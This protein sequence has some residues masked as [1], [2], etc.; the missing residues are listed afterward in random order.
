MKYSDQ[1]LQVLRE[2]QS[3]ATL[4]LAQLSERTGIAQSTLWRKLQEFEKRGLIARRVSILNPKL[5]DCGLCVLAHISLADHSLETVNGFLRL[6]NAHGEIQECHKTS[7]SADY[8]LKIRVKDMDEYEEFLTHN[9]LR[10]GF[11][12][13]VL[14]NFVM[15]SE[16]DVTELPI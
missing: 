9:F 15:K 7:G 8:I 14:S 1:D 11:V 12:Q 5:L 10:S 16:K 2:L 4:S 13:N 3:D 6:V